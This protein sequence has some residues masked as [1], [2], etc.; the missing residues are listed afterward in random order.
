MH[1]QYTNCTIALSLNAVLL[2]D[3]AKKDTLADLD[4]NK[5]LNLKH[6]FNKQIESQSSEHNT[7]FQTWSARNTKTQHP[8]STTRSRSFPDSHSNRDLINRFK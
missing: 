3:G 8:T 6:Q 1:I 2:Y 5:I 4:K 7:K